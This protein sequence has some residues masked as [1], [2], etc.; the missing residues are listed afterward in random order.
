MNQPPRLQAILPLWPWLPHFRAIA[1]T[2]HLPTAARICGVGA[3]SLSR[4]LRLL[5]RALGHRLFERTGR[6]LRLNH[7]GETLLVAVRDAMRRIDDARADLVDEGLRGPLRIAS[8]GAGTTAL[9]A[10]A[11]QRLRGEHP[12]LQPHLLT[13]PTDQVAAE[14][15]RGELDVAFQ[16]APL[17]HD[18]LTV[19]HVA[20]LSRG[21]YARRDHPLFAADHI[22][23]TALAAAEFVA[24]PP[25]PDGTTPDGWPP[26]W[27]RRIA[28]T[29]D[30][31]RVGLEVCL[32]QGLC[33]VLP[34]VLAAPH[35]SELRRIDAAPIAAT[36]VFAIHRNVL[37]PRPSAAARLVELVQN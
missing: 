17:H 14:L 6:A 7:N 9:V 13:R 8:S 37:G 4:S 15:L 35:E 12:E 20:D 10:P 22:E 5:E 33:A 32:D 27:S 34:D 3:S 29:T 19:R 31:V 23:V 28:M 21:V 18:S 16:E 11:V 36:P 25:L 24:P 1:E 26:E 2:E 30:Q